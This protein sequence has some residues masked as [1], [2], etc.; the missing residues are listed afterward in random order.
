MAS[1]NQPILDVAVVGGGS[2]G[3]SSCIE[4]SKKAS[5]LRIALFESE[6][7][8]G[9]IP[10]SCHVFFGLRDLKRLYTGPAYARKLSRLIRDLPVEVH[11]KSTVLKIVAGRMGE[12]HGLDVVSPEGLRNYEARSIILATGCCESPLADRVIPSA[13]PAGI[14]TSWQLQQM[15]NIHHLTPGNRA[16]IVGSEHVA[17]STAITL[18]HAG[19]SIAGLVEEGV[20]LQTYPLLAKTMSGFCGFPIYTG[21]SVEGISGAERVEAVQLVS[22]KGGDVLEIDCDTLIITGNFRPLSQ[23]ID[24]TPILRD[25]ATLGPTVDM[26]LMTTVPNIYAAGNILRG[27]DMHDLCALEGRLAARNCLRT[28]EPPGPDGGT[29]ISICAEPP[30]RY[31]APQRIV[32]TKIEYQLLPWFSPWFSVQIEHTVRNAV[33]EA[34]S[35]DRKIW[36]RRFS[37]LIG[38]HRVPLPVGRF[39]WNGVD[40]ERGIALR[41][42][43]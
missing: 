18:R 21:T 39:D 13:R 43:G 5:G 2:A 7:E 33:L 23:L 14:F 25:T 3:I 1:E 36:R 32:P 41:I 28:I 9:G 24:D 40:P 26:N 4:L 11:T 31:V 17:L 6:E 37:R 27:G 42:K 15:V 12:P 34:W 35:G 20:E 38:H 10:R 30:I 16:I 19:V 8:L 29:W 22:R